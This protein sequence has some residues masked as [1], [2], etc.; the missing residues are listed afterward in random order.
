MCPK[1]KKTENGAFTWAPPGYHDDMVPR[2][3][4]RKP[5]HPASDAEEEGSFEQELLA[6]VAHGEAIMTKLKEK[7]VSVPVSLSKLLLAYFT[8][9]STTGRVY[10]PADS[11]YHGGTCCNN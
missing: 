6:V 8:H 3:R 4:R 5:S 11:C 2:N 10:L 1:F 9:I 7:K